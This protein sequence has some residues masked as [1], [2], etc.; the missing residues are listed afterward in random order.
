MDKPLGMNKVRE[1]IKNLLKSAGIDGCFTNHSLRV[2]A[3]TR[4][5]SQGIDEQVIK[6]RTGHCS[7]A[8]RAY[9]RTD[10]NLLRKAEV[11]FVGGEIDKNEGKDY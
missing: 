11:A 4:M 3:A 2:T 6:E 5:Y 7:D 9:K 8:V 10:E 1:I